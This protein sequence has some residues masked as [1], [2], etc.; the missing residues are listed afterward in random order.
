VNDLTAVTKKPKKPAKASYYEMIIEAVEVL[1]YRGVD[2][3]H[4]VEWVSLPAIRNYI[5]KYLISDQQK[6][7]FNTSTIKAIDRAIAAGILEKEGSVDTTARL[8]NIGHAA[9]GGGKNSY[10]FTLKY[11]RD[12]EVKS[13]KHGSNNNSNSSNNISH[14]LGGSSSDS[15]EL[16]P[17][18]VGTPAQ[19]N[20]QLRQLL[21][22]T[23]SKRDDFLS[24]PN[25]LKVLSHFLPE[26]VSDLL[27]NQTIFKI[28]FLEL[29]SKKAIKSSSC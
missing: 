9:V 27:S 29:F 3:K 15:A 4:P 19:H 17:W 21:I 23:R 20:Q 10:R 13:R 1:S 26:K 5:K 24:E 8:R 7:N 22:V 6:S 12:V 18:L 2:G 16:D 14:S 11:R 28:Y 25:R